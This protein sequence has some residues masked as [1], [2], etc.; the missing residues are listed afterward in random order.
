MA[1]SAEP[2]RLPHLENE[3]RTAFR[4]PLPAHS[5]VELDPGRGGV[6]RDLSEGG[7]SF[8]GSTDLRVGSETRLRLSVPNSEVQ[9]EASGVVA[10][11]DESATGIRFTHIGAES[12]TTLQDWLERSALPD[13]DQVATVRTDAVLAAKVA[14]LREIADLQAEISSQELD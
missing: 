7:V 4:K 8:F 13:Q 2:A 6:S 1:T 9:I 5:L 12:F 3:R 10:W 11:T 14:C